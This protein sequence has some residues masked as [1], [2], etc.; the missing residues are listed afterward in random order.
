MDPRI[1]IVAE[2]ASAEFG[3]EAVLPLHYYRILRQRDIP[4]WMLV[5][6]RTRPELQRLFPEDDH[7]IYI[8]DNIWQRWL[9]RLNTVLPGR[10]FY[11]TVGFAM[12]LMTQLAQ[13]RI[14]KQIVKEKKI[15]VIHQ[16][17]PV[18]PKEPS[19]IFGMD[20]PVIIGP[21]NGGMNYPPA[22]QKNQSPIEQ[23][24]LE[25]GRRAANVI[26]RIM[27]G[28]RKA[29]LL[30][31]ANER[32]REALPQTECQQVIELVENGVDLSVWQSHALEAAVEEAGAAGETEAVHYVFV[33][34]LVDWKAVD[35]LLPA[36]RQAA[37][38][39]E[40]TLTIIG[41]GV[42]RASLEHQAEALGV[43]ATAPSQA[44]R[45]FFAGW[46]PQQD[47]AS[48]LRQAD[49]LVLPSLLECG[50]AVVLEAMAVGIPA[51]ATHWGGPA[52][53][54]DP[55]CGIL[56]EPSSKEAFVEGLTAAMVRLARSPQ[57]RAAM[58]AAGR[59]KVL[60]HFDWNVKV[61]RMLEIYQ[62]VMVSADTTSV[63]APPVLPEAASSRSS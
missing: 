2:H 22:F 1:L 35:L 37:S 49:A 47:C 42:E 43:L 34:R 33:G 29:A 9:W 52:D 53:Y 17:I 18:S 19:T 58:G 44:G 39:A 46:L 13:R 59:E 45:I 25:F 36:F 31:V 21:M 6:A 32:T 11:F 23:T 41:D 63:S 61:D 62:S 54:L 51:I 38:E 5:H 60:R 8:E 24:T 28:K 57:E 14:A 3:G 55:S 56:V 16:P 20:A 27:P 26:N 50:G 48:R 40:I 15:T 10:L 4:S 30:M 12:R 7:I